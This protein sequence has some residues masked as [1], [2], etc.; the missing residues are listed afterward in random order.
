MN[1]VRD[2]SLQAY[3]NEKWQPDLSLADLFDHADVYD[4]KQAV[5]PSLGVAATSSVVLSSVTLVETAAVKQNKGKQ[6][7]T[8]KVAA[9]VTETD[10]ENMFEAYINFWFF[11]LPP[12]D[13]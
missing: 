2:T 13:E 10:M 9:V 8:K 4:S 6:S 3:L 7:T 12:G 11:V 1:G 5:F